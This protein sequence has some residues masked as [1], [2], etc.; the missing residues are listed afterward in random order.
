MIFAQKTEWRENVLA[1]ITGR[2]LYQGSKLN[3]VNTYMDTA[4]WEIE[5]MNLE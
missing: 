1:M 2:L 4:L 5:D 3:L